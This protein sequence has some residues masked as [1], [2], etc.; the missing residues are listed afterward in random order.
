MIP[1]NKYTFFKEKE[2]IEG[3]CQFLNRSDK[4]SMGVNC[5]EFEK[6]FAQYQGRKFGVLFNSGA[7]A[8]LCLLQ[9]LLNL[10]WLK[11]GA[12]VGFSALTWSTNVMPLFQF[13]FTPIPVDCS[14][15]YLNVTSQTLRD[16]LKDRQLQCMFITN[17]LGFTGD[18]DKIRDMCQDD[19]IIL[20]EDNCE[21][22]GTELH[23]GKAGNF[24]LAST[25]SFYVAHHLST[26]EGGMI[27]TDSDELYEMLVIS[28]ANGWDRNLDPAAQK[29]W[30]DKYGVVSEFESK[31]TFY[32]LAYNLR[33]TEITGFLGMQQLKHIDENIDNR[34]KIYLA[35]EREFIANDELKVLKRKHIAKLSSFAIPVICARA[36]LREKYLARF[37]EAG[38]EVRP[39]IA[40]NI[41]RQPFYRKYAGQEYDLAGTDF[42]SQAGFYCGSDPELTPEEIQVIRGCLRK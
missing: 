40:G 15:D 27:C 30:R 25:F 10:G 17:A 7:S 19:G 4:F 22:L 21:S 6:Q 28:R 13:G 16:R 31:Y 20:L 9:A 5:R 33:P 8:N 37:V 29:R 1:L 3:L 18:L 39:M 38:V 23:S 24:G 34:E 11:T 14:P 12:A 35:I 2:A 42:I 26:I 32:D 41:C 36:E